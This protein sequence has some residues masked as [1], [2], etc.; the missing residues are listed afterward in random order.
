MRGQVVGYAV[1]GF[2]IMASTTM[3]KD[4]QVDNCNGR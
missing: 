3:L 1:D 2:R 4:S